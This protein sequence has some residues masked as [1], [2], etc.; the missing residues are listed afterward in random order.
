[1]TK[2]ILKCKLIGE[3]EKTEENSNLWGH[4]QHIEA[5]LINAHHPA[6]RQARAQI[7]CPTRQM[8]LRSL[9]PEPSS[10]L[11]CWL[12]NC[13]RVRA[14]LGLFWLTLPSGET[15]WVCSWLRLLPNDIYNPL[16]PYQ[17]TWLFVTYNFCS[18]RVELRLLTTV[19][20]VLCDRTCICLICNIRWLRYT[21]SL[22]TWGEK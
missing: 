16:K 1:M 2:T 9:V 12:H 8:A 17:G 7:A 13:T 18:E 4:H 21:F 19:S 14:P 22:C 15:W 5:C 20:W 11:R 3:V 6:T 10:N